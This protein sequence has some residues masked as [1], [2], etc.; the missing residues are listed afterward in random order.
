M[1]RSY[2][3]LRFPYT[4]SAINQILNSPSPGM[5]CGY[6]RHFN[7]LE[8]FFLKL[9]TPFTVP[10][11]PIHHDVRST[12]PGKEYLE[13]LTGMI[14]PLTL[15]LPTL[16]QD[17]TYGFDPSE[18]LRPVFYRTYSTEKGEY[19]FLLRLD[20]SP[21]LQEVEVLQKGTNDTTPSFRTVRLYLE[22][23]LLY[24]LKKENLEKIPTFWIEKLISQSWVGEKER[25]YFVQGIWIDRDLSKF[26]SKLFLPP[27]SRLY[28]YFPFNSRYQ[29]FCLS[30][31]H[32]EMPRR[33]DYVNVLEKAL[34]FLRPHIP[35]IENTLKN[36]PF[37]ENL[38]LYKSLKAT[39]PA[40]WYGVWS[41]LR[42]QPYINEQD[43][44]E[45][46]VEEIL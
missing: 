27:Q 5:G 38:E 20:L 2:F 45:Y 34:D 12:E 41:A 42:V 6:T 30:L 21:R 43:M 46:S 11:F 16:F 8:E 32:P 24:L 14:Q 17:L 26:F 18:V 37:S 22:A 4:S 7:H 44:K 23:D 40:E 1:E 31:L 13:K 33:N 36:N 15:L 35:A 25:G 39:V 29:T 9:D 28:P 19:L 3:V 10:S